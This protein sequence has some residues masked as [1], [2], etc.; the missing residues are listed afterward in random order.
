MGVDDMN[1]NTKSL[2]DRLLETLEDW[3]YRLLEDILASN[4][5]Q[6]EMTQALKE[7]FGAEGGTESFE[8]EVILEFLKRGA[9][10]EK[11]L[12]NNALCCS[13]SD[14]DIEDVF[15]FLKAGADF[16][17]G[18]NTLLREIVTRNRSDIFRDL[19]EDYPQKVA[20]NI[21]QFLHFAL[22]NDSFDVIAMLATHP[23]FTK[24]LKQRF[25]SKLEE[26][27]MREVGGMVPFGDI[28]PE[29]SLFK[30]HIPKSENLAPQGIRD[31]YASYLHVVSM[32]G[33]VLQ[34]MGL[35]IT[36]KQVACLINNA[37][38]DWISISEQLDKYTYRDTKNVC[39][40][41]KEITN[42]LIIPGYFAHLPDDTWQE[43]VWVDTIN[44]LNYRITPL[45]SQIILPN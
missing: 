13:A 25:R 5:T 2:T 19:I 30:N 1:D 42:Y 29:D 45:T 24:P 9:T 26:A 41:V 40:M 15:V 17:A 31:R 39:D 44:S 35:E 27:M 23:N 4:P 8:I 43:N 10:V 12:L 37:Q 32:T 21:L 33:T 16:E 3:D 6:A 14:F 28:K 38:G 36:H 7:V 34:A 18:Y 20:D 11:E 22:E